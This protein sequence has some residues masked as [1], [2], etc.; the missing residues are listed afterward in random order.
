MFSLTINSGLISNVGLSPFLPFL[1]KIECFVPFRLTTSA[2]FG[3]L[4]F[5]AK[6]IGLILHDG[7]GPLH[8]QNP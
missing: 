3:Y 1:D 6:F 4:I 8:C 2:I 5:W 7:T